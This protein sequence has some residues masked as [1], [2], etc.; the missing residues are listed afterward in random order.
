MPR[1]RR[2]TRPFPPF[3]RAALMLM[4]V[5][6]ALFAWMTIS[7]CQRCDPIEEDKKQTEQST[8]ANK[9]SALPTT[10]RAVLTGDGRADPIRP[11]SRQFRWISVGGD[12]S[13]PVDIRYWPPEGVTN[14]ELTPSPEPGGPPYVWRNVTGGAL[15]IHVGY[16]A[17]FLEPGETERTCVDTVS[18][19]LGHGSDHNEAFSYIVDVSAPPVAMQKAAVPRA[20]V[21]DPAPAQEVTVWQLGRW[22]DVPGRPLTTETCNEWVEWLSGE[23]AFFALR[24]PVA[25]SQYPTQSVPLPFFVSDNHTAKI[26][27]RAAPLYDAVYS[28]TLE[29]RGERAGFCANAL[30]VSEGE[31]WV[32]LGVSPESPVCPDGIDVAADQWGM[33]SQLYLDLSAQPDDGEGLVQPL[34]YCYEGQEQP[35]LTRDMQRLAVSL[36]YRREGGLG[37]MSYPEWGITCMGPQPVTVAEDAGNWHLRGSNTDLV[38]PGDVMRFRHSVNAPPERDLEITFAISSTLDMGWSLYGGTYQEPD[39]LNPITGA[40]ALPAGYGRTI[41]LV[42]SPVPETASAGAYSVRLT[43]H[44]VSGESLWAS[45]LFWVGEWEP[46]LPEQHTVVVPLVLAGD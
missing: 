30:P 7:G 9:R 26:D 27:F 5:A 6:V 39:P 28:T 24:V 16:E 45:D 29:Y 10:R 33:V 22:F 41:W 1:A 42:S 11:G 25:S 17:P 2:R 37:V 34:Y 4:L 12:R 40:Y 31:M 43:A 46:P 14:L 15:L 18:T 13:Q 21:W 8:V 38:L 3:L 20:P 23:D 35:F 44:D 36:G 32:P 19:D